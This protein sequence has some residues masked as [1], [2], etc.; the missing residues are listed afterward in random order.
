MSARFLE[1][2]DTVEVGLTMHDTNY[3]IDF[4]IHR[5]PVSKDPKEREVTL[6]QHC[7][8]LVRRFSDQHRAKFIGAGIGKPLFDLA[9]H[10]CSALWKE[11]DIVSMVLSVYI[12]EH[13][14]NTPVL[15]A[16]D[17][18]ADSVVRKLIMHFGPGHLIRVQIGFRNLVEVDEGGLIRIVESLDDYKTTVREPTWRALLKITNEIKTMGTKIAFFSSTPQGG[19]VALMRHALIRLFKLLGVD[20]KW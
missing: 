14:F 12:Q 5:V 15:P 2:Q 3:S 6:T 8:K 19:G 20:A 11:L 18:Q 9:P 10:L 1:E 17:E 16:A 13:G 7:L 4:C